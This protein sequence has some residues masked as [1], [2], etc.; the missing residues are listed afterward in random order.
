MLSPSNKF[1][2]VSTHKLVLGDISS[3]T[4]TNTTPATVD[5]DTAVNK[6]DPALNKVDTDVKVDSDATDTSKKIDP[7]L[8]NLQSQRGKMGKKEKKGKKP[9]KGKRGMG[10]GR[11]VGQVMNGVSGGVAWC[12][13]RHRYKGR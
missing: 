3:S 9:K 6:G 2:T 7:A 12:H 4:E 1:G 5:K 8:R 11:M 13:R 10:V